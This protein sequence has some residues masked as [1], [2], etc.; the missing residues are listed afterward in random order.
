M[1]DLNKEMAQRVMDM[2]LP[3][4]KTRGSGV[5]ATNKDGL[6]RKIPG[7][8]LYCNAFREIARGE[9]GKIENPQQ[10]MKESAAA[11]KVMEDAEKKDWLATATENFNKAK[12]EFLK[13][14][15]DYEDS[16]KT[17]KQKVSKVKPDVIKVPRA[18]SVKQFFT[19]EFKSKSGLKG[20]IALGEADKAWATCQ[21]LWS[22]AGQAQILACRT[23][24]DKA[25]ATL[26]DDD[27]EPYNTLHQ[28][29][30]E[31]ATL[32]KEYSKSIKEESLKSGVEDTM[33]A[34]R[35]DA[36]KRWH[37]LKNSPQESE[38][39]D[40]IQELKDSPH[41]SEGVDDIQEL[42][43]SPQESEGVDDI[44]ELKDSP[45]ES[46][47]VDDI[48]ELKDSP[49]ESERVDDIHDF[50]KKNSRKDSSIIDDD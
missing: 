3:S 21:N 36:A 39:V 14:H 11:W 43:D 49:Q 13:E 1:L 35:N 27:R 23:E 22:A 7:Y 24:A 17:I 6:P 20:N 25:W 33:K 40:D 37:E 44:Q 45:H 15:P 10:C 38:G 5:P 32:F 47:G 46:E 16:K 29:S 4:L 19:E 26:S 18:K 48:Q 31:E 2:E 8:M 12:E 42:K 30:K 50:W 9:D 28:N 34:L 41:E